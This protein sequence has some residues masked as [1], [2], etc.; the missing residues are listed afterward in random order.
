MLRYEFIDHTADVG[1][2][3]FGRSVEELFENAAF[4]LFD[5][6]A[7]ITAVSP[8]QHRQFTLTRDGFEELLVEWLNA[9]LFVFD[10]ESILFSSF[11]VT[12]IESM[13][14]VA[15]ADGDVYRPGTH[16]I[17]TPV[18]AATYHNL[19]IIYRNGIWQATIVLD[20]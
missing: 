10:T 17:K 4:A 2:R 9:L 8:R 11:T 18:K 6:I 16:Q 7:D 14:L 13:T 5:I 12:R 20:V 1:I 15:T 3:V 19:E